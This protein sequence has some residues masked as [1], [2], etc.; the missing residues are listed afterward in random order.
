MVCRE[1]AKRLWGD[2]YFYR[3]ARKFRRKPSQEV[4]RR[5]F[6]EFVLDPLYKLYSHILGEHP[7][8]IENVLSEFGVQLRPAA[9]HMDVKPLLK[10][11]LMAIFGAPTGLVDMIVRNIPSSR[12]AA[13]SKVQR[14]YT[15]NLESPMAL[16]MQQCDRNGPLVVHIAK[17]FPRQDCSQF[18]AFGRI[19]SGTIRPGDKVRVL[20]ESYTPEDEED[21]VEATVGQIWVYQS[22]YRVSFTKF[23][24]GNLV[25]IEGLDATI[26]KTATVVTAQYEDEVYIFKPLRFHTLSV[27]KIATE[28]LKPAELPKMVEGLRK[29]NKSYPLATAKVEESGEHTIL[30]TGE[31]YLDSLMKDLRE[32]Y[33]D[34]EVKVADPVVSFNETVVETSSLKCFAETPNKR[35]KITI[36][37]EPL[38]KGLAEDIENGAV[39]IAWSKKRQGEFFRDKY[40][41]DV[42]A[43]RS[44]WAFGPDKQGPNILMDDTLSSEVDKGLLGAVR[45]SIIQVR[46]TSVRSEGNRV[47]RVSNGEP[48]MV[49]CVKNLCAT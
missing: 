14:H 27:V 21:S 31:I 41:W 28:P 45:E 25:L 43:S 42:L 12:R 32:L 30:G 5:S 40:E 29:I 36:I 49:R 24:A 3:D 13:P 34:I 33:A 6:V 10:E 17:L 47:F 18:D 7:K 48:E 44:V 37:A 35:N 2:S 26:M 20:G 15:G 23:S 8:S 38:D 19:F 22:R 1:L 39:E 16:S 11:A 4:T 46:E 9:Y